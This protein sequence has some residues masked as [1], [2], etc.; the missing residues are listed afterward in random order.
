[1][2]SPDSTSLSHCESLIGMMQQAQ[3]GLG[4]LD[5]ISGWDK[6]PRFSLHNGLVVSLSSSGNH[7]FSRSHR[8]EQRQGQTFSE[9]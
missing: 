8:F 1:L 4:Q 5:G 7:R 2:F 6:E 9:E 3:E